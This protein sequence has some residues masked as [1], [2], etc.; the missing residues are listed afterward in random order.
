MIC[1]KETDAVF[2]RFLALVINVCK[3]HIP[4]VCNWHITFY[5]IFLPMNQEVACLCQKSYC[6]I[7]PT[8]S[9]M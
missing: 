8:G 3:Q 6:N 1:D 9:D 5:V 7:I 4:E 2:G